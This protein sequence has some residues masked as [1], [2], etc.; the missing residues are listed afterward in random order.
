M[1]KRYLLSFKEMVAPFQPVVVHL[2]IQL[3]VTVNTALGQGAKR[4][5]HHCYPLKTSDSSSN[6]CNTAEYYLIQLR[7]LQAQACQT[8]S[9][10]KKTMKIC[11]LQSM[12]KKNK[13][14]SSTNSNKK[15]NAR[16]SIYNQSTTNNFK[17][18]NLLLIQVFIIQ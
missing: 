13:S 4:C 18:L 6:S 17:R 9:A 15:W 5:N 16:D 3:N 12:N 1:H 7:R 2:L 10:L 8:K 11:L 14:I